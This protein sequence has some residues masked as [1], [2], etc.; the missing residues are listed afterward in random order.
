MRDAMTVKLTKIIATLGPATG[1]KGT[2]KALVQAGVN[3][4]R[5]NLS[6]GNYSAFRQWIEWIRQTEKELNTFVGI[7]LDLQ[8]PKIRVGAFEKGFIHIHRGERLV[9]TTKKVVGKDKLVPVQY[10]N[11]HNDVKKG[12]LIFLDDGNLCVEVKKIS[13]P[14]VTVEVK[15]GGVLSNFKGLNMPDTNL[16]TRPMTPK[17]KEDLTFGLAEGVDLV[18][19]SF[20]ET[21]KDIHLLRKRIQASGNKAEIIAKIE[22]KNAVSNLKEIVEA[23]DGVMVARGDLGIEIPLT[24][25]PVVQQKI[26]RECAI[27]C[28]PAIVATQ[29]LESMIEN[30]RPTRAEVSDVS[31]AVTGG[32]DA[33]M[34]SAETALGK[35]PLAAVKIMTQTIIEMEA[36]LSQH[37]RILPWKWFF[38][39]DPPINLG[40]AYSSNRMV[41]LLKARA[42]L[43]FTRSGSRAKLVAGPHPMVPIFAFTSEL[44]TA[45]KLTLLRGAIPFHVTEER[46]FMG[47]LKDIFN[48]L[49]TRRL[50]KKG[51][52]VVITTGVP[53]G[54]PAWTN[55]MRVEEVG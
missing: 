41:E 21:S 8:G 17:D 19:L 9:L 39:D 30:A 37:Q 40:M 43:V 29:M 53:L 2:I 11:F 14:D 24:E 16:S 54:I 33:I 5:L 3:V 45:R 48:L 32:A 35:H 20:V 51:D 49:K 47:D 26:L 28:K 42:L 31:N 1:K 7:L 22:R 15:A 46:A 18:A 52:R 25:V 44:K 34:L 13:G 50:V 12:N 27:Q 4:F 23:A 36:F 55:V 38:K 10:Q 6:H